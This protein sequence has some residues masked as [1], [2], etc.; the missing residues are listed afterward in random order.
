MPST[1]TPSMAHA[2]F[3]A[4]DVDAPLAPN[5]PAPHYAAPTYCCVVQSRL[6][7]PSRHPPFG[8]DSSPLSIK[9]HTRPCRRR[10]SSIV[11]GS[12]RKFEPSRTQPIQPRHPLPNENPLSQL[13]VWMSRSMDALEE[14]NGTL[15]K[16]GRTRW[17]LGRL[18][19]S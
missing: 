3:F 14:G 12:I 7:L 6:R 15:W 17:S 9:T 8:L 10:A 19:V 18:E 1:I 5:L 11:P 4:D 13:G 2:S 16:M